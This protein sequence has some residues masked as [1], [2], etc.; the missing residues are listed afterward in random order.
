MPVIKSLLI[1]VWGIIIA[2]NINLVYFILLTANSV[3]VDAGLDLSELLSDDLDGNSRGVD[4][5]FDIGAY[6]Y[7]H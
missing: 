6:E 1:L 3:A 7:Q 4:T 2:K 5:A